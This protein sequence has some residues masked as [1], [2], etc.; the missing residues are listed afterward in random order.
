LRIIASLLFT[1]ALSPLGYGAWVNQIQGCDGQEKVSD[2]N[3]TCNINGTL[4][5][6]NVIIITV[7]ANNVDTADGN[8]TL[9]SSIT[10]TRSNTYNKLREFTNAQGAAA[11]GATVCIFY[12][13]LTTALTLA[14]SDVITVTFASSIAAKAADG[15]EFSIGA[16]NV[17][18]VEGTPQDLANDN[19]DAGSMTVSG[20]ASAEYLFYRAIASETNA[21]SIATMSTGFDET[22]VAQT[23]GGA[24]ASNMGATWEYD[25]PVPGT[26]STSDPTMADTTADRASIFLALKE[27][28]PAASVPTRRRSVV[29]E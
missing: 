25:I 24:E 7:A 10:D 23:S 3:V 2:A 20:L 29:I 4:E 12:S 28:A 5:A 15:E 14:G 18:S 6:G 9:C 1:L 17:I 21:A 27:A 19:A 8:T 16:G 13:I 26:S 22:H 11:A